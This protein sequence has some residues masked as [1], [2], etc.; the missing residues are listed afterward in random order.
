MEALGVPTAH[1]RTVDDR[2]TGYVTIR[3]TTGQPDYTIHRP[4]AYDA[5]AVPRVEKPDWICFG[6]LL[7]MNPNARRVVHEIVEAHPKARK[8]YDVNLRRDSW[9]P[10]LVRDLI[11][12]SDV[13]KVNEDEAAIIDT[14]KVLQLCITRGERGCTLRFEGESVHVPGTPAKVVD[15]VGAGDAWSAAFL[16]G[17]GGGWPLP[18][19]GAFANRLG[20]LVAGR[21]GGVPDWSPDEI[22]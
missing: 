10:E 20:A 3:L 13:V 19:I 8:F 2:P 12:I 9:T 14:R 11:A 17:Y 21:R 4:A 1:V 6:T 18:E 16:H 15:A 5:V 7:A 22:E